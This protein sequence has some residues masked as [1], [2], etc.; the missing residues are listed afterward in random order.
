[1]LAVHFI[2]TRPL[3]S[4]TSLPLSRPTAIAFM[5]DT[6]LAGRLVHADLA[7]LNTEP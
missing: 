3:L 1:M 5:I 4:S 6:A 2:D 7:E